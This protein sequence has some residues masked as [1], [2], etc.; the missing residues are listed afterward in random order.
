MYP[1]KRKMPP[2]KLEY[3][4]QLSQARIAVMKVASPT[5]VFLGT[6]LTIVT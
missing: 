2:T 5:A 1:C 4:E 6:K 3:N